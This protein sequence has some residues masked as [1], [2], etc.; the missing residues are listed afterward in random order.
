MNVLIVTS[1]VGIVAVIADVDQLA[2]VLRDWFE[3]EERDAVGHPG[4]QP[5]TLVDIRIGEETYEGE[6]YTTWE[7][8]TTCPE[9]PDEPYP[10]QGGH[11]EEWPVIGRD[12]LPQPGEP[13]MNLL[14]PERLGLVEGIRSILRR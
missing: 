13:T 2:G 5:H 11:V 1:E 7:V 9:Y 12:D 14:H 8:T 10:Y 6:T 4:W 3:R